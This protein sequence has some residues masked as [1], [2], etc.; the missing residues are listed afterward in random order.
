MMADQH[1]TRAYYGNTT[2]DH[3]SGLLTCLKISF[4]VSDGRSRIVTF[5]AVGAEAA[6]VGAAMASAASE[7]VSTAIAESRWCC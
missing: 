5:L 4:C 7:S 6:G 3:G 1:W 2:S